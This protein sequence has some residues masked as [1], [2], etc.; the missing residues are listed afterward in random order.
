LTA[1]Q[2]SHRDLTFWALFTQDKCVLSLTM[3]EVRR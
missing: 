1:A 2:K 3:L